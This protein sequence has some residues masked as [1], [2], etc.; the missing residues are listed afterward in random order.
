MYV[1]LTVCSVCVKCLFDISALMWTLYL[2]GL[3]PEVQMRVNDELDRVFDGDRARP[4]SSEDVNELKYLDC[5]MKE[6]ARIYP[7]APF[8]VRKI[9][10]DFN[11]GK[12]TFHLLL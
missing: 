4:V 2:L 5:V 11:I 12:S 7:P 9:L 1:H 10:N 8:L 3:Y 6:S